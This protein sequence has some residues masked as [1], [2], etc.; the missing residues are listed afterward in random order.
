MKTF[1]FDFKGAWKQFDNFQ[2]KLD[3][4]KAEY[5]KD[6][7]KLVMLQKEHDRDVQDL[8]RLE[9]EHADGQAI[10]EAA[11]KNA[12]DKAKAEAIAESKERCEGIIAVANKHG[13]DKDMEVR[14]LTFDALKNPDCS[15]VDFNLDLLALLRDRE[16]SKPTSIRVECGLGDGNGRTGEI[17]RLRAELENEDD[18]EVKCVLARKIKK[19]RNQK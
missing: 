18:P 1:D 13:W 4:L 12:Y 19:L 10:I 11:Y 2:A 16:A 7:P 3:S 9:K 5:G 15:R 17:D 8:K 6:Q 14:K